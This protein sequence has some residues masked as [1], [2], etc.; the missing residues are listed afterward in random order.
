M[1]RPIEEF[2]KNEWLSAETIFLD[3][4]NFFFKIFWHQFLHHIKWFFFVIQII[5]ISHKYFFCHTNNC[6]SY[7]EFYFIQKILYHKKND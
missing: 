1:Y 3:E 4:K 6:I 5:Q 2:R 7:N